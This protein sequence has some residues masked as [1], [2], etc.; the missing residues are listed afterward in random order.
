MKTKS[1][2]E[3]DLPF[4]SDGLALGLRSFVEDDI[5]SLVQHHLAL[6][7]DLSPDLLHLDWF[8][9][10]LRHLLTLFSSFCLKTCHFTCLLTK[11]S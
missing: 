2:D 1:E 10:N 4:T 9:I 3:E 5:T 11:Q 6:L 8:T 7:P